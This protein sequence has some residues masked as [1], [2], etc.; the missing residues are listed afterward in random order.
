MVLWSYYSYGK[1]GEDERVD[2]N[3]TKLNEKR[4][5]SNGI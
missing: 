5:A 2:R 3:W 4:P 1:D